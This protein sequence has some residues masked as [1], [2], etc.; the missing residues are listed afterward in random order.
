MTPWHDLFP[1][2]RHIYYEG[3]YP[4]LFAEH[5]LEE[6]GLDVRLD[7]S[8]GVPMPAPYLGEFSYAFHCPPEHLD[9]IYT[10]YEMGS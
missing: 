4:E 7:P 3:R 1:T 8:W 9:E 10:S 5:I 2:G 6:Y